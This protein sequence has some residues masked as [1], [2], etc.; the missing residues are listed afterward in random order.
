MKEKD[1]ETCKEISDVPKHPVKVKTLAESVSKL[2]GKLEK[3]TTTQAG[4]KL[5]EKLSDTSESNGMS[6]AC[7]ETL[8]ASPDFVLETPNLVMAI[9]DSPDDIDDSVRDQSQRRRNPFV[10]V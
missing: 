9:G 6:L 3:L 5:E 10:K 1:F 4:D 2:H 7:T 8:S